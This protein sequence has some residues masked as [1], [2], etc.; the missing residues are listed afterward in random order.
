VALAEGPWVTSALTARIMAE[1]VAVLRRLRPGDAGQIGHAAR[2]LRDS[3][4]Q[5]RTAAFLS[6]AA[7]AVLLRDEGTEA[8][9]PAA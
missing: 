6:P 9:A 3:F 5:Q 8:T 4:A 1:E 7:Y 2:L